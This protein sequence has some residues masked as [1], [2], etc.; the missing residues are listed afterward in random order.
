ML[1][2]VVVRAGSSVPSEVAIDWPVSVVGGQWLPWTI[3]AY[4]DESNG[5]FGV[6][7]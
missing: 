7:R 4:V 5:E 1:A 6:S 2:D 3:G